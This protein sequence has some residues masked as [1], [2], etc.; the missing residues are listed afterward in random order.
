ME[1]GLIPHK[2]STLANKHKK[3]VCFTLFDIYLIIVFLPVCN[4]QTN[5]NNSKCIRNPKIFGSKMCSQKNFFAF[6][7]RL[8]RTLSE[9]FPYINNFIIL[10]ELISIDIYKQLKN[11]I[12]SWFKK[13]QLFMLSFSV[14][15]KYYIR[16]SIKIVIINLNLVNFLPIS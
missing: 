12:I 6:F 8:M 10:C 14:Y 7:Y 11:I 3:E 1:F 5:Y 13:N 9:I 2:L 16:T 4:V 15:L